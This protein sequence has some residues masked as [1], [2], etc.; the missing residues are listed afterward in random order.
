MKVFVFCDE[1][2]NIQSVTVP[3]PEIADRI[4]VQ[5]DEG[6]VVHKLDVDSR[7]IDPESLMNLT[8]SEERQAIYDKLR[9]ML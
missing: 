9:K 5:M 2:G 7:M 1:H 4:N 3:N 6:G 8:N